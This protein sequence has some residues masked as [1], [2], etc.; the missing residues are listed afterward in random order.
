MWETC[1][2]WLGRRQV[3]QW[4]KGEHGILGVAFGMFYSVENGDPSFR[5]YSIRIV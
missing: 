1:A 3:L 5:L 2:I 4:P